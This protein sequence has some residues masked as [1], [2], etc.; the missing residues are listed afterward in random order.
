MKSAYFPIKILNRVS[1]RSLMANISAYNLRRA[2]G[3]F[4][5]IGIGQVMAVLGAIVGVRWITQLLDPQCYG[6]LA[7]GLTLTLFTQQAIWG[8]LGGGISRF[9]APA[10]EALTLKG[11]LKATRILVGRISL[12]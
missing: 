3:E 6:E 4:F 11:Y 5:W 8:P 2:G 10:L 9:F 7:L 12:S 1:M